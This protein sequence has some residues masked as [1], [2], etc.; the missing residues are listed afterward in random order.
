MLV[1]VKYDG[2]V[3]GTVVTNHNMSIQDALGLIGVDPDEMEDINTPKYDPELFN[4]EWES[5]PAISRA[6][7]L[8]ARQNLEKYRVESTRASR[9]GDQETLNLA[10]EKAAHEL[11]IIAQY[12]SQAAA[13]LG[14]LT[15]PRK[16]NAA[17]ENG[18][19]GGRRKEKV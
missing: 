19:R 11:A 6:Q 7:Y 18:K 12:K 4:M 8:N 16:A 13:A 3:I 1:K 14:S 15:S 5:E 10:S 2:E 17:R 9:S